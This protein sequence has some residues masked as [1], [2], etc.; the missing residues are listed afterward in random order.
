MAASNDKAKNVPLTKEKIAKDE[1]VYFL[2]KTAK[3][4]KKT[5]IITDKKAL[6]KGVNSS[7]AKIK[8]AN[9]NNKKRFSLRKLSDIT[10]MEEYKSAVK[11]ALKIFDQP[12][13]AKDKPMMTWDD[14]SQYWSSNQGT[15]NGECAQERFI[16]PNDV[17]EACENV[18]VI[19]LGMTFSLGI[20]TGDTKEYGNIVAKT[21]ASMTTY[22]AQYI[23]NWTVSITPF[24]KMF[25]IRTLKMDTCYRDAC[26][27]RVRGSIDAVTENTDAIQAH[28]KLFSKLMVH[29]TEKNFTSAMK[30]AAQAGIRH[31]TEVSN[32]YKKTMNGMMDRFDTI[33]KTMNADFEKRINDV[34]AKWKIKYEAME[35][36]L[37]KEIGR[38]EDVIEKSQALNK[39]YEQSL[40][41]LV[42][43]M[44]KLNAIKPA[45]SILQAKLKVKSDSLYDSNSRESENFKENTLGAV[46]DKDALMRTK[47]FLQ[48]KQGKIVAGVSIATL[49]GGL[50]L[51]LSQDGK[52]KK[53]G[54]RR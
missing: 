23:N 9:K 34:N 32:S 33:I 42:G 29:Q 31:G 16:D 21:Y 2:E 27:S 45:D 36:R 14:V 52:D 19:L 24:T 26:K 48:T 7:S 4:T 50:G 15:G 35:T 51:Y 11:E 8:K 46:H 54:R 17:A 22:M 38:L 39:K 3:E 20:L 1:E 13:F 49:L 6:P 44:E 40:S 43:R 47:P 41:S 12:A 30:V 25:G 53:K 28:I 10:T 18:R 37:L 5:V